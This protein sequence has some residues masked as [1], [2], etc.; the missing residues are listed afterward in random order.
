MGKHGRKRILLNKD[1]KS[2]ICKMFWGPYLDE[3]KDENGV[4][5]NTDQTIA[6]RLGLNYHLIVSFLNQEVQNHFKEVIRYN[7]YVDKL[8]NGKKTNTTTKSTSTDI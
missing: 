6:D 4:I 1:Q 8:T 5:D 3:W 7:E 2:L